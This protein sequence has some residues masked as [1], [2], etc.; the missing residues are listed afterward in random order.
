MAPVCCM[1]HRLPSEAAGARLLA[2]E[3]GALRVRVD[4]DAG[5][6]AS[7]KRSNAAD[8]AAALPP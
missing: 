7:A 2:T 8:A 3:R 6:V 1:Q 5:A 4:I